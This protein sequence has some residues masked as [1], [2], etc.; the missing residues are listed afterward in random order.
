MI[1]L[2]QV[3][4]YSLLDKCFLHEDLG[5]HTFS[6]EVRPLSCH[7]SGGALSGGA[8]ACLRLVVT[9][10]FHCSA[11]LRVGLWFLPFAVCQQYV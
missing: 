3:N 1:P 11:I 7:I 4:I 8:Q 2:Y 5:L 6:G 9:A 10:L